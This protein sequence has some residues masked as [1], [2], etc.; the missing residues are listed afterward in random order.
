MFSPRLISHNLADSGQ[1]TQAVCRDLRNEEVDSTLTITLRRP[2]ING[3]TWDAA[4]PLET[5]DYGDISQWTIRGSG[6]HPFHLHLYHM[7]VRQ[8]AQLTSDK[9]VCFHY[10]TPPSE[11]VQST[12]CGG[13]EV[14]EWYDVISSADACVVRF[15]AVDVAGRCV[16]HW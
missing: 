4:V 11:Q 13:H 14:G 2:T 16:M 12:G 5:I 7:Q 15:Q 9:T 8:I 1:L 3:Q 6:G 10:L